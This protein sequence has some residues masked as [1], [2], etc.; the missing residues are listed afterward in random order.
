MAKLGELPQST[1]RDFWEHADTELTEFG[2]AKS[3]NHFL[4]H[5]TALEVECK[6]CHIG[7][8]LAPGW[9]LKEGHIYNQDKFV[10]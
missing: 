3:C 5:R 1:D 9:I 7:F 10:I 4:V 8:V 2:E 6:F